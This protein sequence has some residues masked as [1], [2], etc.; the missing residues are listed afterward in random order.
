MSVIILNSLTG[1]QRPSEWL[2]QLCVYKKKITESTVENKAVAK[3]CSKCK[4]KKGVKI[5]VRH[6]I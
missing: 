1:R 3:K 2:K 6:E 4:E 5:L